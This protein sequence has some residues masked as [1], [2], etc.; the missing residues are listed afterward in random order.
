MVT[1][2]GTIKPTMLIRVMENM[3]PTAIPTT[4]KIQATDPATTLEIEDMDTRSI[5]LTTKK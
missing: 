3:I 1:R 5:M 4:T 2:L